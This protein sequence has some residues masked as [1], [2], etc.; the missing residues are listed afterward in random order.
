L[1]DVVIGPNGSLTPITSL[2][3]MVGAV[4]HPFAGNDI[5]AYY[6]QDQ[7]QA[8]AWTVS[9]VQGGWGNGAFPNACGVLVPGSTD[10]IGFNGLERALLGQRPTGSGIYGRLLAGHLQG[11]SRLRPRKWHESETSERAAGSAGGAF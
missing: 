6:G 1:A 2:Q 10:S 8:N 3:F 7:T 4:I 11:R 5:Y 9:G